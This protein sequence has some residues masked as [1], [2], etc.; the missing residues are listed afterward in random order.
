M[1]IQ[2][3]PPNWYVPPISLQA[4]VENAVKHNEH[5]AEYPLAIRV[6]FDRDA[7]RIEN[8]KRARLAAPQAAGVGLRN[9]DERCRLALGRPIDVLDSPA[10]FAVRIPARIVIC[11]S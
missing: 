5:S 1:E 11:A 4:V 6:S 3:S 2:Q 7:V 8:R 9:L 10:E